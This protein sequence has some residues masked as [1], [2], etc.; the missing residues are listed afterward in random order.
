MCV[1]LGGVDLAVDYRILTH[2]LKDHYFILFAVF[3]EYLHRII[4][5]PIVA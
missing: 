4:P 1:V 5:N 3:P 2:P